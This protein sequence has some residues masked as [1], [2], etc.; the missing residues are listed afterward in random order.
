M[1]ETASHDPLTVGLAE[2]RPQPCSLVI[3]GGG[4]DLA[5]RKL[6]PALYNLALDGVLPTS[7]VVLGFGRSELRDEDYR[8]FAQDGIGQYSGRPLDA[9]CWA[10]YEPSL[11]F[12][13]GSFDDPRWHR[14]VCSAPSPPVGQS[15][16]PAKGAAKAGSRTG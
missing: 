9:K 2:T 1:L 10:D 11:F 8:A 3:L 4:G 6:F 14:R 16:G 7:F 15:R 13:T 5:K 12:M